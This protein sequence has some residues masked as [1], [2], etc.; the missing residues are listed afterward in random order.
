MPSTD[1]APATG[2]T[3][4]H[5][6]HPEDLRELVAG[7]IQRNPLRPLE[8]EVFLVQ[9][10]GMAQWLKLKLA[11][12]DAC[13]IAAALD[14]QMPSRFLWS[15]YRAV[16]G[17]GTVPDHSPFDREPLTWRLLRLL[18]A[19]LDDPLFEPLRHFLAV[20]DDLRKRYQLAER[21]ADLF[22]QYQVYRADWLAAWQAGHDELISPR[23]E[24]RPLGADQR[25]QAELWRRLQRD[26]GP[27][28]AHSSR[29]E[30]HRRFLEQVR[31]LGERPTAL[32]RRLTVFGIS[33]LPQQILEALDALSR[34]LAVQIYVHNPCRYYWADII[35][36]RDLLRFER[37]RHP[38]K[39]GLQGLDADQ[40]HSRN[41]PLL[42]AWGKQGRDYIGLLYDYDNAISSHASIDLFR[43][44]NDAAQPHLLHQVQQNILDLEPLP[45]ADKPEQREPVA[46]GDRSVVFRLAHSRQ[47][48]VE[49]LQDHLLAL[50]DETPAGAADKQLAPR[51]IIVMVPDIA[52]Y[53]PHIEA[54]FGRLTPD[55]PRYIPYSIGDRSERSSNP[56][57]A[58]LE[59]LLTLPESRFTV[60]DVLGL[61][62][63]AAFRATFGL[64]QEDMPALHRWIE[65]S[66]IR[67]GLHSRQREHLD[68]PPGLDQNSWRF[69]LK[70]MLLGYAGGSGGAW[71]EIEPF[72]EIGGLDAA[73]AGKL[74][75]VVETLEDYWQRLRQTHS[76]D[77]WSIHLRDL[78][79]ECLQPGDDDAL[80]LEQ[81]Q[82]VL[83]QWQQ[84]CNE[85]GLTENLPLSVVRDALLARFEEGSL[86]QRFLAGRINFGTLMPM[87]A[88]PFEVVCLLG[89]NDGE[90]PR[91]RPPLDFDLMAEQYRPGDR[92]RQEDDRYLFLEALLS[93]RRG[94]YLSWL[95]RNARDNSERTPS[96]LVGQL[97]DYLDAGWQMPDNAG[98][99]VPVSQGLTLLHPLQ[100]FSR[101]YF[102]SLGGHDPY[103]TYAREWAGLHT[104]RTEA[105]VGQARS[106]TPLILP[107]QPLD[108]ALSL[109]QLH[110]FMRYPADAFFNQRLNVWFG[111]SEEPTPEDEPFVLDGLARFSYRSEIFEQCRKADIADQ[112]DLL[113][114]GL[115]RLR[116]AGRLP[117]GAARADVSEQIEAEVRETLAHW[118][119]VMAR[120]PASAD[121]LELVLDGLLLPDQQV[122]ALN[123]WVDHLYSNGNGNLA[124]ILAQPAQAWNGRQG[125]QSQLKY[126]YFIA[127]WLRHVAL[128]AAGQPITSILVSTDGAHTLPV[129]EQAAAVQSLQRLLYAWY[130]AQQQCLPLGMGT[131]MALLRDEPEERTDLQRYHSAYAGADFGPPGDLGASPALERC[132]PDLNAA[133]QAGLP[134]WAEQVYG[135]FFACVQKRERE[136]E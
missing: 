109:D 24:R 23:G 12:D 59:S 78:V 20:D 85:A 13:G 42:A 91:Q 130:A 92:S 93:A 14:M 9:S 82:E 136:H 102:E 86:S 133:W 67:W 16:L 33:S 113:S 95:G 105:L 32:P 117:L 6:N 61:L 134:A 104:V 35:E 103:F 4:V 21:L 51:D 10:N 135:D 89:M 27:E 98:A 121:P 40:L 123:D 36:E 26:V 43:D 45:P 37:Y 116:R 3:I 65:Q 17:K 7:L 75:R 115:E 84:H 22:D 2:L 34:H 25:W 30:V 114:E 119:R 18:P 74:Y 90:Y 94:F 60:S 110:R 28:L 129:V 112:E 83:R 88:I 68:L 39:P 131:A 80:V 120:W 55:D 29:A 106:D 71:H 97:R 66:G 101:I 49:I 132:W 76:P 118:N 108:A 70:R 111:R 5:A 41:N 46:A 19:C 125:K 58:A 57:L 54:V 81:F 48:E 56:I 107:P 62:D 72:D 128:A 126:H 124:C 1:H 73:I 31:L 99:N 64:S 100:P 8:N 11:Q 77:E 53:A 79:L 96:V 38:D 15:A 47:R 63:V 69:G 44:R 122:I 50:L 52:A 87:R 127:L